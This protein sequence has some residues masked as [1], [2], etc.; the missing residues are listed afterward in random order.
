[1]AKLSAWLITVIGV[2]LV[3]PLIK[4]DIKTL[5]GATLNAWLIPLLVLVL[6]ISKLVRNYSYKKK[7]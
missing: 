5:I 2:L 1:M 4:V 6:G 7:R 3:L